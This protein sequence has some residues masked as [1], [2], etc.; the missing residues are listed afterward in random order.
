MPKKDVMYVDT[1]GELISMY[2]TQAKLA[3]GLQ[4]KPTGM[5]GKGIMNFTQSQLES[6]RFNYK[7]NSFNADTADFRLNT[8]DST[9]LAFASKNVKS[10]IDFV[11]RVGEFKSNGSGSYVTFPANKYIC[12][13]DQF[14]WFMDQKEIEMT[15]STSPGL[16]GGSKDTDLGLSGSEF[17]SIAPDQD[18]LRFKAPYARYSLHDYLI[19][20]EKVALIRTADASVI[21]DS[22]KVV[23][24]KDAHMRTLENARVI[25]NTV[26]KYHTLFNANIDILGRK[27]YEGS[28]YYHYIDENKNKQQIHFTVI[29]VDTSLQTTA[30]GELSDT[31][32]FALSTQ[33]AFKGDVKLQ[34]S[35][36]NLT[37]SGYAK[38][39]FKCDRVEKNWIRFTGSIDPEDVRIPIAAPVTDNGTVIS[40]CIAQS[41]DSVGIYASFLKP[42]QRSADKEIVA[43]TGELT[44]DKASK[45]YKIASREKLEKFSLPGNYLSLSDNNCMVYGEGKIDFAP[46]FG[47]LKMETAGSVI[48]N[49]NNDSTKFDLLVALDFFFNEESLKSMAQF[50]ENSGTLKPTQEAGNKSFEKGVAEFIGLEKADKV[51]A[52]LNLYGSVK[53]MPE[54]LRHT[55][56]I[57]ELK[58]SWNNE[59]RSYRSTGPIGVSAMG[60]TSI[61]K[62]VSGVV[63]IVRKRSGDVIT[64][65][66]EPEKGTWFFFTYSRGVMQALS[67]LTAFNDAVEKEK[68]DKRV[69]KGSKDQDDYEYMLTTDRKVRDFIRKQNPEPAVEEEK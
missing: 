24:E 56:F 25:S 33:F 9:A 65:Y 45:E 16:A 63:E 21:P 42:K 61:G 51:I 35:M 49:L 19:K 41:S 4:L 66:L 43:A 38:P 55:L 11:N 5:T 2:E 47:Q 20:A 34:A 1:L 23:I 64:I 57:S 50:L 27:N 3:G 14:K 13:I 18:S 17:I 10:N 59:T 54:E 36:K 69:V 12:Y 60:K 31:A 58:M 22:G 44:F 8:P 39:N 26:T 68:P 62:R 52:D 48:N 6:N 15:S 67:T 46:D 53:K 7:L 37:F 28:A 32:N 40:A 30:Y 29:E